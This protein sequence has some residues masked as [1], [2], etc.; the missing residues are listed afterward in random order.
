MNS[1]Q[2]SKAAAMNCPISLIPDGVLMM[3]VEND[4]WTYM[5]RGAEAGDWPVSLGELKKIYSP[6]HY[7]KAVKRLS[8]WKAKQKS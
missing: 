6:G 8:Q 2:A 1:R 4:G 3:Q 5:R 7:E